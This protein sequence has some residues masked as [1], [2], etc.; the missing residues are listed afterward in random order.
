MGQPIVRERL[1]TAELLALIIASQ[2]FAS[3]NYRIASLGFMWS[4]ELA[5][6]GI[7]NFGLLDQVAVPTLDVICYGMLTAPLHPAPS[8]SMDP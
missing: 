5:A 1:V 6:E 8:T 2:I 4:K 7:G 3:M